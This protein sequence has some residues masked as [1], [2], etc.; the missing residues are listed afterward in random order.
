[1][2]MAADEDDCCL[3]SERKIEECFNEKEVLALPITQK[4]STI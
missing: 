3:V 2:G 4:N 1:M